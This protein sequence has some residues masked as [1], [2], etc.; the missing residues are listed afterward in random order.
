MSEEN[1]PDSLSP[2]TRFRGILTILFIV[3]AGFVA[4]SIH[5]HLALKQLSAQNDEVKSTLRETQGQITSL[6]QKLDS[7][8]ATSQV[9]AVAQLDPAAPMRKPAPRKHRSVPDPRW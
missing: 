1:Q 4:Y 5:Q 7:L 9:A 8:A 2:E 6:L 3:F